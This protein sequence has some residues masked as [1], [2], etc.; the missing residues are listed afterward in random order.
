MLCEKETAKKGDLSP[1]INGDGWCGDQK[2]TAWKEMERKKSVYA[3][4]K[5]KQ[6]RKE[7]SFT[8][9]F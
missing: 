4:F 7:E 9:S 5:K 2:V 8:I 6:Q 1:F 3:M